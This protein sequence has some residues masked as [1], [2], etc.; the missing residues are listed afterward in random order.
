[1]IQVSETLLFLFFVV[2]LTMA[3]LPIFIPEFLESELHTGDTFEDIQDHLQGK[4]WLSTGLVNKLISLFPTSVWCSCKMVSLRAI[5]AA[6][7][8]TVQGA[9]HV[10]QKD[11]WGRNATMKIVGMA[12]K[13]S[14]NI[15]ESCW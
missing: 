5:C 15:G 6:D 13:I 1:M 4:N 3:N 7:I 10:V 12:S 2:L 11:R 14:F 8:G 9:R